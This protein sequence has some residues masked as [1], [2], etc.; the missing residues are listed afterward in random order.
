MVNITAGKYDTWSHLI[1]AHK[2]ATSAAAPGNGATSL[3]AFDTHHEDIIHDAQ[4]D[5]Y[6]RRLA[7]CSSDAT[8]KVFEVDNENH[9]LMDTL[10]GHQGPVWQVSWAHPKFGTVLASCS[11]DAKVLI[12]REYNGVWSKVI[13]HHVHTSSVNSLS[14]GPHEYGLTLACAS[15]DGKISVLTCKDDASWDVQSIN[16][17]AIGV[18]AVSWAP[19]TV[20]GSLITIAGNNAGV[21]AKRLV[22]GGCDNLIKIWKWAEDTAAWKEEATLSGHT[23]WVRDVCW[24]PSVGLPSSYI[25]SCSQDKTV[26]IWTQDGTTP[27]AQWTRKPLKAEPFIDVVWRVSWSSSGNILAVS[28]G[29]NKVSMWKENLEGHFD[30]IGEANEGL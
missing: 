4:L 19:S 12:W 16:A 26:C 27:N 17:H 6:G 23:D 20:S 7:T 24:A 30:Q 10:R 28:C 29:D 5:Y 13:E 2:Q 14:W 9:R 25:A 1:P 21:G 22:S 15:S 3:N 8:I 11:Y 18:N